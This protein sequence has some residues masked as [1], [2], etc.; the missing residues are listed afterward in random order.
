M[1]VD[2]R[3]ITPR[4]REWVRQFVMAHWGAE[5]VV[6]H[7]E[8]MRPHEH[9]GFVAVDGDVVA[10][11]ITYR[12]LGDA[13]EVITIDS[14]RQG[15]G[16]GTQLMAAVVDAAR[17]C[18]C[19]RVWLM[20]TNDNVRALAFYQKRGFVLVALHRNAVTESR[21]I[22]PGIPLIAD[23]GIPIRDELELELRMWR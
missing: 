10:G 4:D 7:G 3:P 9:A 13:C 11:L 16:I 15:Q 22:K 1:S 20:T 14:L 12:I 6:G 2:L 21:K 18:G 17:A 8:E 19:R 5:T 23:N